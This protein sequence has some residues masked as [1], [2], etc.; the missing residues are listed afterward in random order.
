MLK[1]KITTT[2]LALAGLVLLLMGG[3]YFTAAAAIVYTAMAWPLAF[4]LTF[5]WFVEDPHDGL[6]WFWSV[7]WVIMS[8]LTAA[9]MLQY[10][11]A[12]D[13]PLSA[14]ID[15]AQKMGDV[16]QYVSIANVASILLAVV[17][18]RSPKR[19]DDDGDSDKG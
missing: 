10:I 16:G 18:P 12:M 4:H 13:V 15:N 6:L 2:V 14:T 1:L 19:D 7:V 17:M 8:V 5:R 11:G 3:T 9:S